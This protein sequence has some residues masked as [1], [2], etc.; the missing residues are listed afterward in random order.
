MKLLDVSENVIQEGDTLNFTA[1]QEIPE[2]FISQLKKQKIESTAQREKNFMH[3]ASIPAVVH[4]K[5]LKEGFDCT[6][7]PIK[8][9]LKRLRNEHLDAFIVTGK[10][11]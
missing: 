6:R 2:D 10:R 4:H 5:W 1:K 3:V 9:T 7:A 8:E 11:V